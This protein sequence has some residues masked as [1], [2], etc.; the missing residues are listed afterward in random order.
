MEYPVRKV[1]MTGATGPVGMAL[2]QKMLAEGVEVLLFLRKDSKK[3]KYLPKHELLQA[4]C[5]PLEELKNYQP[6]TS[7][8]DVFF[9]MGWTYTEARYRNDLEKQMH[10]LRY[11]CDAVELAHRMGCHTF[12]GV[13]SQAEYGRYEGVLRED[14]CCH[15]KNAYGVMKLAACHAARLAC[16]QLNI[17][18]MWTRITSA[19]GMFDNIY[20]VVAS[21]IRN[22]LD[23]RELC[24]SK[25]EQIWDFV[26]VDDVANALYLMALR[27]RKGAI[28]PLGGV[29][30]VR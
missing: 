15:P 20:T 5:C 24:F 9:H 17:R 11:T 28:Y 25:C 23:G 10:N 21:T 27:G 14:A 18:Y 3:I 7:D 19:Y 4:E 26:Y 30:R 6:D 12:I 29:E 13:G 22:A 2:I 16:E 1:V 8:Y